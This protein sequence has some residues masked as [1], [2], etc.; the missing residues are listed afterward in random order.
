MTALSGAGV[1]K[2]PGYMEKNI[3]LF[4]GNKKITVWRAEE[5]WARFKEKNLHGNPLEDEIYKEK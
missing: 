3:G 1:R 2:Y 5:E 4:K